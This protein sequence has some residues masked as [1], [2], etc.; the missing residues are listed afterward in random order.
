M[1]VK[2]GFILILWLLGI[3]FPMAW[4]G[5]FWADYR[6]IF[7][8]IFAPEW[9]HRLMHAF[10]YA[11]LA[12]FL[13][14]IFDLPLDL[15]TVLFILG[16]VL[17]VGLIQEGLQFFSAVQIL[18]W[19]SLFVLGMDMIGAGIGLGIIWGIRKASGARKI[20]EA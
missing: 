1:R 13:V 19:N 6:R 12:I 5:N 9:M 2:K 15:K 4:L 3:L 10:L 7:D 11:G 14:S 8:T 17:L 20:P 18:T 16:I